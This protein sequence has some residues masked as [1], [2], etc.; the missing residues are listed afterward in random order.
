MQA[1]Q[2]TL[3]NIRRSPALSA[4]IRELS[5]RLE[6]HHSE[7]IH[8]RVSVSQEAASSRKGRLHTVLV[9]VRIR[10][11]DLVASRQGEDV[12]LVLREAFDAIRRELDDVVAE[13]RAGRHEHPASIAEAQS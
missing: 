1:T 8:C 13:A 11:R 12:Y 5:E 9:R 6:T 4:R 3:H 10:G 2:I 7:I